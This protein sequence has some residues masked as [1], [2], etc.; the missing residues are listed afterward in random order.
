MN[1]MME[2]FAVLALSIT[3]AACAT[4]SQT[5]ANAQISELRTSSKAS[6]V[7][8]PNLAPRRSATSI[9]STR[10]RTTNNPTFNAWKSDFINR[11]IEKGYDATLV[12]N[13]IGPAVIN[14]KALDRDKSQPEFTKPI[15][16]YVKTAANATRLNGGR[17]K[18]SETH[19]IFNDIEGRYRVDRYIL[20]AI[21]GL[22]SAYGRIQG[23][24]SIVSAL[25]TFAFEGRR[26]KFGE[27]QL[28]GILDIVASGFVRPDQLKGS[29]AGGMGMPQFIPTTFR[30]YAID[31]NNDG[32]KDLWSSSEDAMGS[33]AHYL[34][35]HGWVW[36]EPVIAEVNLPTGFDY[37]LSDGSK[38]S[39]ND[40]T[41]LGIRPASGQS[42]SSQAG[43]INA[44]LLIPAGHK[45]PKFLTF[46]NFDVIKKYNNSTSYAL[47]ITVLA[48]TLKGK[49]AIR[50]PWPENDKQLSR[51][52]KKAMQRQ[53]TALGYNTGGV[54]GQI[55][56]NTRR[57]IR[58]WQNANGLP[59]DGYVGKSLFNRIM[60]R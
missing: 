35:R 28:W 4:A 33:A 45:G 37:G 25:A 51:S 30:D 12:H 50:T 41:R 36:G 5:D 52:D 7:P 38:K 21:W 55:G 1:H 32:N 42:W 57:A 3:L 40:W 16:S 9:G 8:V 44:K 13:L 60:S 18:L 49:T 46:K 6:T 17:T 59:A 24:H 54:D 39:I 15:W 22:E 48:E 47:G 14:E 19:S 29:W 20:T 26:Q 56:P 31:F 53:L 11:A 27:E 58:A 23:D 2:R 10:Y 43:L 34:S